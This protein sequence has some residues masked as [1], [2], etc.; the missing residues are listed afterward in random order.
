MLAEICDAVRRAA[1]GSGSGGLEQLAYLGVGQ[2]GEVAVDH[3]SAL[4]GGQDVQR[5]EC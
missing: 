5:G 2:V 4:L 3:G 1:P